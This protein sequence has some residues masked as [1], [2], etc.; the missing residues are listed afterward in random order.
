MKA[1]LGRILFFAAGFSVAGVLAVAAAADR[2]AGEVN[3][4]SYRQE[5][6]IRPLLDAFTQ[7]TGIKVNLVSGKAD[8][9]LERLKAEGA[10][11]PADVLLTADVGRLVRAKAAGVL[12][13]V[14]S[15]ELEQAIPARYRDDEGFWYGLSVRARVPFYAVGRVDPAELSTYEALADPKW[16]GRICVRSSSNVYNQSLLA[17]MIARHGPEKAEAWA[18]GIVANMA[19]RPQG[20]DRD[21]IKAVAAGECDIAIANTYYYGRMLAAEAGS[22][23]RKAAEAVK[24]FWPN[25]QAAGGVHVNISGA[26]VTV[27]ARN[28]AQAIALIEF[29]AGPEAQA[30]YAGEVFEY[31]VRAGVAVSDLVAAWGPFK[32]DDTPLSVFA[33]YQR[34]AVMIFDRAGW[35]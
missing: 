5:V 23:E 1:F 30:L 32:A 21:Q 28:K 29:L 34:D 16:R 12:Q 2:T 10:N 25:Q 18:R 20:G 9:L 3:I 35:R 8:A 13:A 11:S 26:G 14:Q 22:A 15:S 7:K 4:Y 6:L 24:P 31:P 17:A 33:K 27:S 19:R